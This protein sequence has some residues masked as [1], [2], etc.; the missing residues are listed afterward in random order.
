[1]GKISKAL[2]KSG[3]EKASKNMPVD[4]REKK[5]SSHRQVEQSDRVQQG[6]KTSILPEV[7][8][9]VSGG[10]E[11]KRPSF[12]KEEIKISK[13]R[14]DERV[15][16]ATEDYPA[17]SESF[18]RLRTKILHPV[19]KESIQSILV[20]SATLE[21]GKSFVSANL[22]V[23][24]AQSMEKHAILVDC[25]LRRPSLA[26]LFGLSGRQG[27]VDHLRDGAS[28]SGLI[29][30]TGIERL[31]IIPAGQAPKNPSELLVSDKMT[32]MVDELVSRYQDRMVILDSPPGQAAS[33]T[34]V[35]AQH[36]DKVVV[37]VKWGGVGREQVKKF[38]DAI[39]RDKILGVVF[40]AFE[41]T[42]LDAKLQGE[43]YYKYYS[44]GY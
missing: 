31:S 28:L 37:V 22:G 5:Q 1:M 39:G 33:E 19:H 16:L 41:M 10:Q 23:I 34:A 27:L 7:K 26:G 14:W 38:I 13:E 42:M 30:K 20:T 21:E 25:D 6:K 29:Q 8:L 11:Q 44:E 15:R 2:S 4:Q 12:F 40:N 36:V 32:K 24:L 17:I 35:L 9:S 43:G 3:V 18:R